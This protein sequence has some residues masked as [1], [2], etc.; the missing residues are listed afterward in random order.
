M[1]SDDYQQHMD[2]LSWN[3]KGI[4]EDRFYG[5]FIKDEPKDK[6]KIK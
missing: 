2:Q 3:M 4:Y 5:L 6:T 1:P